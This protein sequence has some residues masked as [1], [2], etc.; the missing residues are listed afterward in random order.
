[1]PM[2][3][4]ENPAY[5]ELI[6]E[7]MDLKTVDNNLQHLRAYASVKEFIAD[8]QLIASNALK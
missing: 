2:F 7:P 1:M 8:M 5:F 6:T 4:S 3:L